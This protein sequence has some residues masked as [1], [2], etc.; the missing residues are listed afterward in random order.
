MKVIFVPMN[1][2][3]NT[4][5]AKTI[6]GLEPVLLDELKS[7]GCSDITEVKRGA[8]F[9]GGL[10]TVYKVNY[11]CRSAIRVLINIASFTVRDQK[12]LYD[13]IMGIDWT[14]YIAPEQTIALDST[15]FNNPAFTNTMFI[16]QKAKDAIVDQLRAKSGSRPNVDT[17]NADI[18]INIYISQEVCTVSL[19]SS[20]N[21]LHLRGY[22]D[23]SVKA[24]MSE[25]LAAGLLLLAGWKGDK[26]L[27]DPMCGSGTFLTEAALIASNTPP[28]FYRKGFGFQRWKNF[29]EELWKR[30]KKE[31]DEKRKNID[32]NIFG[33]DKD[34]RS[35]NATRTNLDALG[36]GE[37]VSVGK[38]SFEQLTPKISSG[39]LIMNPPYGERLEE[40]D[41]IEKLYGMIGDKLKKDF[42]GFEAWIITSSPAGMKS[43]GL[44]PSK[45]LVVFN[46][47]LECRFL[48]YELYEGSRKGS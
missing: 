12:E 47:P 9:K 20:G 35:T 46:G 34:P 30:V 40:K 5:V 24:P 32:C 7:L 17:Q 27:I 1:S 16:S 25:V 41:E 42:K 4:I 37:Q 19:D 29:D 22:K 21:S 33:Y 39:M 2:D 23:E 43:V 28:G 18:R 13:G 11:N 3:Q 36:F 26:D 31:S 10:E 45:K 6:P 38:T 8:T 44:R 48:K 15:S 14:Q